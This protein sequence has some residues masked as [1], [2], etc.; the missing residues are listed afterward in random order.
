M[1]LNCVPVTAIELSFSASGPLSDLADAENLG[2]DF[3]HMQKHFN[4]CPCRP[5][6]SRLLQGFDET[7]Q[8]DFWEGDATK[9]FS[10]KNGVFS[11]KEG[12]NS[13][14]QGFG[15]D[16]YRKGNSVKRF[17]PFT[18]PPHSEN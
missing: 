13:V 7:D 5:E 10:M 4:G 16:F 18:E 3:L 1:I 2:F 9:H 11:E 17:G 12:G 14:N 8:S 15:K 6:R